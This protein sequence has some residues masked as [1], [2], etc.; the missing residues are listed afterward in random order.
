MLDRADPA[1]RELLK[2]DPRYKFEA[3]ELVDHAMGYAHRVMKL[4]T[5]KPSEPLPEDR[6]SADDPG[7]SLEPHLTGPALCEA[8]RRYSIE[9]FGLMAR[10]VLN[11]WGLHRTSDFGEIVFNLIAIGRMK[12]TAEDRRED[13]NNVFDFDQ[14]FTQEFKA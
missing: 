4:G 11:T 5:P 3:Y 2:S 1:L 10:L 14:A 8:I 9:M 13:F 12:K 7:E 6:P